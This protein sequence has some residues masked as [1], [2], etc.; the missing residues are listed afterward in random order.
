MQV[1]RDLSDKIQVDHKMLLSSPEEY[2]LSTKPFLIICKLERC[3]T[4]VKS[5]LEDRKQILGSH[6]LGSTAMKCPIFVW[7]LS[8]DSYKL[9]A[10]LELH[11]TL[12]YVNVVSPNL[13]ELQSLFA[14]DTEVNEGDL[15]LPRLGQW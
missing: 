12:Q 14:D 1:F 2:L 5:L 4:Q 9:D 10:H 11:E 15:D 3:I 8:P 6:P 13:R 7:G